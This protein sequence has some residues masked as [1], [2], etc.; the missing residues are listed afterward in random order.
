MGIRVFALQPLLLERVVEHVPQLV[1]LER[2]GDEIR[3]AGLDYFDGIFHRAVAGDNDR[4]DIRVSGEGGVDHLAAVHAGQAQVGDDD[5][6][7]E[8]LERFKG[9]GAVGGLRNLEAF[10]GKSFRYNTSQR[11]LVVHEQEVG[12]GCQ[13]IDTPR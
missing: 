8:S 10:L 9:G 5:I 1:E 12:Q 3:G 6:E 4:H 7:G 2:L 13:I 11:F